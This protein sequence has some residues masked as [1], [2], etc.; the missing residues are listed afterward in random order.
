MGSSKAALSWRGGTLLDHVVG[1]LR[2]AG[3]GRLV[4]VRAPDQTLPPLPDDV[5]V[6]QDPVAGRGPLQGIAAGLAAVEEEPAVFVAAVDM[7]LLHPAFV[8][9]VRRAL[10][11]DDDVV[12]PVARG[13]PQPLAAVYR[14]ALAP[15]VAEL[16]DA[17]ARRPGELFAQVRVR[18]LD[19]AALLADPALAA[20]DPRL[21][22]LVNVND[23]D[24]Y[25]RVAGHIQ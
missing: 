8:H 2:A 22:A 10:T 19:E 24:E 17:G 1:V 6:V 7:P 15:V 20:A 5:V 12:L 11:A 13:Y 18:R 14:T 23:P 9:A 3:C 21:D 16:V 4:V 25:D